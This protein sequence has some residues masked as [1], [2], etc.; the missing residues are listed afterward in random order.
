MR[1]AL[2]LAL[3][4][5]LAAHAQEA[6]F[7]FGASAGWANLAMR[8]VRQKN[9]S[10]VNGVNGFIALG[11]P[12]APFPA[13]NP[14]PFVTAR[15]A[16]RFSHA[17]SVSLSVQTF[18]RTLEATTP[19]GQP[20]LYLQRGLGATDVML[21]AA[22][23]FPPSVGDL[24]VTVELAVGTTTAWVHAEAYGTAE[25]LVG[26][27]LL[28]VILFDSQADYTLSSPFTVAGMAAGLPLPGPFVLKATAHY[29]TGPIAKM[30]GKF[31]EGG[32]TTP[33]ISQV[34]FDFS[35]LFL[36]LGLALEF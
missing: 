25:I 18:A 20:Y 24:D 23:H 32:V 28:K 33:L 17:G 21:G 27:T 9:E 8:A 36:S 7:S 29:K 34:E 16:Y 1:A 19:A 30:A 2:L 14:V 22:H 3:L 15:A 10:D 12:V 31:T 4:L 11:F 5:P 26:K 6:R 13:L 35:G